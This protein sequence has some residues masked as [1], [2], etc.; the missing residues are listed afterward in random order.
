MQD[1]VCQVLCDVSLDSKQS[2]QFIERIEEDY[3]I[4]M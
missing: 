4:H 1:E 2:T 3:T